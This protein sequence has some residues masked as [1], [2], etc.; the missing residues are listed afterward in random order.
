[1]MV[2]TEG[3]LVLSSAQPDWIRF[4]RRSVSPSSVASKGRLGRLPDMIR[5]MTAG[6]RRHEWNGMRPVN[7]CE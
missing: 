6:S 7:T 4:Q 5:I 2:G 1:M 3:L